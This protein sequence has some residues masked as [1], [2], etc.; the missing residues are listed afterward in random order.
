MTDSDHEG[1][2]AVALQLSAPAVRAFFAIAHEW[3]LTTDEQLRLLGLRSPATLR[4]WRLAGV[5]A[6]PRDRLERISCLVGIY[7]ALHSLLPVASRANAWI[8]QPNNAPLFGG[9]PALHR[10]CA[11]NVD[12]LHLVRRYL[13]A[14][15]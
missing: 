15:L 13:D 4:R 9:R 14:Q 6:L 7:R 1:G 11:G 12:D 2:R 3:N 8:R 5:K 10:M